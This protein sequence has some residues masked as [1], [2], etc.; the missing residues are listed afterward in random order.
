MKL[1][2]QCSFAFS[3][4]VMAAMCILTSSSAQERQMGGA[5]ITVF[6]DPNFRGKSATFRQDMPDLRQAGFDKKISSLRVAPGEQWEVCDQPNYQGRCVVVFG[7]E[8]DLKRNAWNDIISSLRRVGGASVP[9]SVRPTA[10]AQNDWYIVLYDEP[11]Y[12]GN[13]RNYKGSVP[14]L[15]FNRPA[16][17]V[18]IGKG[19]WQICDGANFTGHCFV[20]NQSVADL[21]PYRLRGVASVRPW[22]GASGAPS[23]P[24]SQNDWYIVVFDQPNY[25]GSP[26]N[27]RTTVSNIGW[28]M[29]VQS[30][31]I[32]KGV[33]EIC[34]RRQLH[35]P[36]RDL[37]Q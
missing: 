31:T 14:D 34:E 3:L 11:N 36:L 26:K 24:P 8:A 30:V 9:P 4:F 33:W 17:S 23:A 20:L 2:V 1:R 16:G 27:Y 32:G 21:G 6:V 10:P 28:N 25:R 37:E 7:E 13:P 5:G 35:G 22:G 15:G 19:I 12:R 18:T 29:R